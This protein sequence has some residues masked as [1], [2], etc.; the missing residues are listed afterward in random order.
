MILFHIYIYE[1]L[2][3][4]SHHIYSD[5]LNKWN[6]RTSCHF[7]FVRI[8][9]RNL[10]VIYLSVNFREKW[11]TWVIL[12]LVIIISNKNLKKQENSLFEIFLTETLL[13]YS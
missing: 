6:F 3:Y 11:E 12:E 4:D 9:D 10:S 5:Y 2:L 1:L 7:N 8:C 13:I